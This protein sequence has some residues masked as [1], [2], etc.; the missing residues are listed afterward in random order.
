MA[1]I[2]YHD[3]T[4]TSVSFA[5]RVKDG[6]DILDNDTYFIVWTTTP[7][8]IPASEAIAVNP[9]FKYDV[10]QPAGSERKFVVADALLGSAAQAYGWGDDY[11]VVKTVQGSDLDRMTAQH[12]Y[13]DREILVINGDHVTADAGTGLV[14]T[15]PGFGEDDFAIG[16]KYN[17]P[18][19]MNVDDRGYMT[20]EAG[21]DFEGVSMMMRML[22]H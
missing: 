2:E 7:W 6:K 3:V 4:S 20:E 16:Q 15:A 13:M 5:E 12:P 18:I 19:I 11:E 10:V 9:S 14:H 8:T 21:P 1:E 17:L 22:F